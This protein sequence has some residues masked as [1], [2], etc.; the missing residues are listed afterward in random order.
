MQ[1]PNIATERKALGICH[2]LEK[3]HNYC[4][5]CKVSVI[6]YYKPLVV[7]FKK[8]IVS[9]SHRLQRILPCIHQYSIRPC[10]QLFMAVWLSRYNH[11]TN[12]DEEVPS[13]CITI[14]VVGLCMDI[15]D[16]MT[17]EEIRLATLDDE[18]LGMLSKYVLCGW[19]SI[20]GE[21]WKEL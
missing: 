1:K 8:D 3:I 9:L 2:G 17:G 16:C 7:I 11:K 20:N 15:P 19:P 5:I 6:T 14:N 4:F 10:Q 18:H 12:R 13:M 21:V